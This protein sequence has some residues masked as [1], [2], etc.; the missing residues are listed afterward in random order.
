MTA[1]TWILVLW[2]IGLIGALPPTLVILKE[3]R[4]VLGT[5]ADIRLLADRTAEAARGIAKHVEPVPDLS[6]ALGSPEPLYE[7]LNRVSTASSGLAEA[8]D[9]KLGRSGVERLG[10]W[11]VQWIT[12]RRTS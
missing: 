10:N 9:E 1:E 12:G 8:V 7:A 5:L 11:I 3:A 4:L 2:S 6:A